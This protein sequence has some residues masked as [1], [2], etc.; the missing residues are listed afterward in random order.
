M[1]KRLG[2]VFGT[3]VLL[4]AVASVLYLATPVFGAYPNQFKSARMSNSTPVSYID[5][6]VGQLEQT[7]CDAL[8][9]T[10]NT[11]FSAPVVIPASAKG[12]ANGVASLDA[13]GKVPASQLP[14]TGNFVGARILGPTG[15][16]QVLTNGTTNY[17]SMANESFDTNNFHDPVTNPSRITIPAGLNG[18][19]LVTA[20]CLV[21]A[22]S[23][24]GEVLTGIWIN[25]YDTI[26]QSSGS[27]KSITTYP[28]LNRSTVT[29]V[30]YL[31]VGDYV[32]VG[33]F[34]TGATNPVAQAIFNYL[35]VVRL[36]S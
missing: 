19:Y 25:R 23:A 18:Y 10:I 13:T 27:I 11:D 4:V 9:V 20:S 1:R 26:G 14:T 30:I 35:S 32:E 2:R 17:I 29:G 12:V 34:P 6:A 15:A 7:I 8:G 16:N 24:A 21:T 36:G 28:G 22:D 33:V 31:N 5:D 3:I